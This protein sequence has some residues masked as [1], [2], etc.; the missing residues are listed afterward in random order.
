MNHAVAIILCIL[1]GALG[2][3]LLFVISLN[4]N[5]NNFVRIFPSHLIERV[6]SIER[7]GGN[8]YIAGLS[9]GQIFAADYDN[10]RSI[11]MIDYGLSKPESIN[12]K[13]LDLTPLTTALKL[14]IDS[15][16]VY[17]MDGISGVSMHWHL[18]GQDTTMNYL[19][20]GSFT[21]G[22]PLSSSSQVVRKLD[23]RVGRNVLLKEYIS[24]DAGEGDIIVDST[25]LVKQIDGFFCTD[26]SLVYSRAANALIYVYAYRNEFFRADTSLNKIYTVHTIDTTTRAKL[27]VDSIPS[28][29]KVTLSSP[30]SIVNR[31]M[32]IN[33]EYI[34]INSALAADNEDKATFNANAVIDVYALRD[35]TYKFS[36][37]IPNSNG[38]R[39]G[40]FLVS[41]NRLVTFH[42]N[43]L[44]VYTL[45]L[46]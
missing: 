10:P 41:E 39:L 1:L 11:T 8:H 37:Y 7:E 46:P 3:Y 36:F 34:F 44:D 38:E 40:E 22:V 15:P 6:R 45:S 27:T 24:R 20:S 30:P 28:A 26:G 23:S 12:F 33:N 29:N 21:V 25:L 13:F 32:A 35:G 4:H 9:P 31:R 5:K 19:R 16:D 17:L 2:M 43:M 18:N 14:T 42:G